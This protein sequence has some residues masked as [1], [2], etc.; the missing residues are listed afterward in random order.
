MLS[1]SFVKRYQ[2]AT[3]HQQLPLSWYCQQPHSHQSS[4]TNNSKY[5][6]YKQGKAQIYDLRLLSRKK[7]GKK[8][9]LTTIT[10][11]LVIVPSHG[12][13]FSKHLAK[14][15]TM[16]VR[17]FDVGDVSR[18][19]IGDGGGAE[20]VHLTASPFCPLLQVTWGLSVK[21]CAKHF[22]CGLLFNP[23]HFS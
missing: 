19:G 13:L 18:N 2:Q 12:T 17:L 3:K 14:A 8:G 4:L 1:D 7:K 23:F 10:Q 6:Y 21:S 20:V 9:F 22:D 15:M 11:S 5:I 16:V